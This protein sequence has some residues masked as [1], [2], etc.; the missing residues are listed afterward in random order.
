MKLLYALAALLVVAILFPAFA[1]AAQCP[2]CACASV[3]L[4]G[5]PACPPPTCTAAAPIPAL[6][7]ACQPACA[8]QA[9]P[10]AKAVAGR[11][12]KFPGKVVK[13]AWNLRPGVI[14]R[15]R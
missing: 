5:V 11:L 6:P 4:P 12:L 10:K 9:A 3:V 14:F 8:G 13:T 7:A 2:V 15:R 1:G